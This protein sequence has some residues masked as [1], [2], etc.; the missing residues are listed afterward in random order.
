MSYTTDDLY[1]DG[2]ARAY[3]LDQIERSEEAHIREQCAAG[4][5]WF[6]EMM[7]NS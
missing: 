7:E 6:I 4:N 2:N 3:A 1:E 5:Q